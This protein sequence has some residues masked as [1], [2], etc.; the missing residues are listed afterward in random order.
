MRL[1]EGVEY[2]LNFHFLLLIRFISSLSSLLRNRGAWIMILFGCNN[3][4]LLILA[5]VWNIESMII[6]LQPNKSDDY[7]WSC[8]HYAKRSP[9]PNQIRNSRQSDK[10]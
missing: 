6:Y 4:T 2:I 9:V 5:Q 8:C 7:G 10:R 1:W 3:K